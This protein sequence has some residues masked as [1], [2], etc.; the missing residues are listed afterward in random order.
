VRFAHRGQVQL[1]QRREL[2]SATAALA[3][4]L[5]RP[6]HEDRPPIATKTIDIS[7]SGLLLRGVPLPRAGEDFVFELALDDH[8]PPLRGR[9]RVHEVLPDDRTRVVFTIVDERERSLI[10]HMAFDLQREQKRAAA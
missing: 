5:W 9:L 8:A 1:L 2:I 4:A 3:C 7:G 10:T 6:G